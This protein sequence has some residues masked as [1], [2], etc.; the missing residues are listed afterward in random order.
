[1]SRVTRRPFRAVTSGA[2]ISSCM[3]EMSSAASTCS[4]KCGGGSTITTSNIRRSTVS[5]SWTS[6]PE[7]FSASPGVTGAGTATRPDSCFQHRLDS[8]LVHVLEHRHGV[9]DGAL[10]VDPQHDADITEAEVQIDQADTVP[11]CPGQRD[12]EVGGDHRLAA[13]SLACE[14]D[15]HPA[16]LAGGGLDLALRLR[17][18]GAPQPGGGRPV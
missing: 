11:L 2:A 7:I 10:R 13:A 3:S 17:L 15:H 1:M 16:A 12:G 14:D 4:L 8:G 9:Y 18:L 5:S 6:R